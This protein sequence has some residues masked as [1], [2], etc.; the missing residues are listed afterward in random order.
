M[1][2]APE[3]DGVLVRFGLLAEGDLAVLLGVQAHAETPVVFDA[4]A[5]GPA[6]GS[7]A[8]RVGVALS[9]E[10]PLLLGVR[11]SFRGRRR[12]RR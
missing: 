12:K 3:T 6:S 8:I 4:L 11:R 2:L 9:A 7:V 10:T 5:E 1:P